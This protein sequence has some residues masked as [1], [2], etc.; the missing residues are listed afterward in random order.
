MN[1][2]LLPPTRHADTFIDRLPQG[3]DTVLGERGSGL[4]QG[5]RQLIAIARE[6]FP[7]P[8]S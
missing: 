4:S 6:R 3:Y 1:R 5:Q 7:D 2:S 8:A